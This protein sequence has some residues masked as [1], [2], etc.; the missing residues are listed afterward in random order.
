MNQDDQLL[1]E[2][3]ELLARLRGE[4]R[5]WQKRTEARRAAVAGAARRNAARQAE[6]DREVAALAD[7]LDAA[8]LDFLYTLGSRA[9][10]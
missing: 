10:R 4:R 9:P 5:E 1:K 7:E 8:S 6:L 3:D 2:T